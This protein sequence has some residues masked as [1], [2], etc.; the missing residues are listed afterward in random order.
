M[1]KWSCPNCKQLR[2]I[3]EQGVYFRKGGRSIFC[4]S[5][6]KYFKYGQGEQSFKPAV[7]IAPVLATVAVIRFDCP[8][9]SKRIKAPSVAAGKKGT[10]PA[11]SARIVIPTT[12]HPVEEKAR[13]VSEAPT[14][15]PGPTVPIKVSFPKDCGSVQTQVSPQTADIVTAVAVGGLCVAA[16]VALVLICPPLAGAIATA[17]AGAAANGRSA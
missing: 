10:C 8:C 12:I 6:K 4:L 13:L 16:G 9:C 1:L 14:A 7:P 3:D 15:S 2:E 17:V 5:C 11:C